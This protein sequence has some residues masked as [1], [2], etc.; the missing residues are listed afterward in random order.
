MGMPGV[1]PALASPDVRSMDP[2]APRV[3]GRLTRVAATLAAGA[4][5]TL[6]CGLQALVEQAPREPSRRALEARAAD[7]ARGF[8]S[9]AD[10]A[11]EVLVPLGPDLAAENPPDWRAFGRMLRAAGAGHTPAMVAWAPV[12]P[13]R[14]RVKFEGETGRD[15]YRSFRMLDRD[16]EGRLRPSAARTEHLPITLVDPPADHERLLGLDLRGDPTLA[17]ALERAAE[18][19]A[20]EAVAFP[21]LLAPGV[22]GDVPVV[23]VVPVFRGPLARGGGNRTGALHRELAGVLLASVP[24]HASTALGAPSAEPLVRLL[25]LPQPAPALP[26]RQG[27]LSVRAPFYVGTRL[28][29]VELTVEGPEARLWARARRSRR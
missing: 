29:A 25:S 14:D 7:L 18:T 27:P 28:F 5:L 12:V 3:S 15:A 11:L 24:L 16:G 10:S 21:R 9:A 13:E 19:G 6:F 1:K 26:G 22:R 8:E 23:L 20:P 4:G 2:A 17:R